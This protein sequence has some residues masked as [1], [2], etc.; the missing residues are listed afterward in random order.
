MLACSRYRV[1]VASRSLYGP[2]PIVASVSFVF[3][4]GTP[5]QTWRGMIGTSAS[6]RTGNDGLAALSLIVSASVPLVLIESTDVRRG[7]E[8]RPDVL[9]MK[10]SY[11]NFTSSAVNGLPSCQR[12]PDRRL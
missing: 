7:G 3:S 1:S 5:S 6:A 2:E 4:P 12:I 11:V 10:Y 8:K 9:A